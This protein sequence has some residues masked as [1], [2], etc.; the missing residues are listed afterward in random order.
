M[1][2]R[3][4]CLDTERGGRCMAGEIL[5]QLPENLRTNEA[6]TGM[7]TAGDIATALLEAKGKVTEFDGKVKALD[8]EVGNLKAKLAE[9]VP[10][11]PKEATDAEKEVYYLAMGR[12]ET[13]DGYEL[14]KSADGAVDEK[15]N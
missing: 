14:E 10:K 1:P 6:F 7:N 5:A 12:P 8:G 3:V 11:L 2:L 4:Q 9:A 13:A 15:F